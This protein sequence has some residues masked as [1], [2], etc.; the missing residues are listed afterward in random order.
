MQTL[1]NILNPTTIDEHL[2]KIKYLNYKNADD[3]EKAKEVYDFMKGYNEGKYTAY[4][5]DSYNVYIVY[6]KNKHFEYD[7]TKDSDIISVRFESMTED[8]YIILEAPAELVYNIEKD[9]KESDKIFYKTLKDINIMYDLP[10]RDIEASENLLEHFKA[11][12]PSKENI[13]SPKDTIDDLI[14]E[15]AN[16]QSLIKKVLLDNKET[17]SRVN[18]WFKKLSE[19]KQKQIM[20]ELDDDL[21]EILNFAINQKNYDN[22][23][24]VR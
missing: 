17:L 3:K 20:S 10:L 22:N 13:I 23:K 6:Y 24:D 9:F 12:L 15:N 7:K 14:K 8:K 2:Y 5:F 4:S 1:D 16:E 18:N 11:I 19:D 21:K